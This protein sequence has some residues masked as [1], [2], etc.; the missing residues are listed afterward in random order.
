MTAK[1]RKQAFKSYLEEKYS[2]LLSTAGNVM[3]MHSS[4]S[5]T[6]VGLG[7]GLSSVFEIEDKSLLDEL[8]KSVENPSGG[9]IAFGRQV[10][11]LDLKKAFIKHYSSYLDICRERTIP[12]ITIQDEEDYLEGQMKEI[13][14]FRRKRNK[15]LRDECIRKYG[16]ICYVCQFDFE[17][18]YGERGKGYIEVHH[19]KPMANYDDEHTITVDD[20]RPLCSNCHSMIHKDP[21]GGATDIDTFKKEYEDRNN[22]I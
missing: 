17:K 1:E 15:A 21:S 3:K 4:L 8:L 22:N 6:L 9:A 16:C 14:Y 20:L 5:S 12:D 10:K 7:K 13:K 2:P 11:N 18:Y 19:L